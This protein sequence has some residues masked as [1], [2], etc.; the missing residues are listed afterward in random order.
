MARYPRLGHLSAAYSI[1]ICPLAVVKRS[2]ADMRR[3]SFSVVV[4]II[5]FS[6]GV[7]AAAVWMVR[8][9]P[10]LEPAVR[11]VDECPPLTTQYIDAFKLGKDGYFPQGVFFRDQ[12]TDHL[13]RNFFTKYLA[14]MQE[15][16]LLRFQPGSEESVY[17]FTWLRSFHSKVVIRVWTDGQMKTLFFKELKSENGGKNHQLAVEQTRNLTIDEWNEFVR[18]LNE[19]CVWRLPS[20]A[21]DAIATDGA[22][23]L[24]EV[25]SDRHYHVVA[26]QSP[27]DS[28]RD[29]CLY[30]L[31][32]TGLPLN[33]Q[34]EIY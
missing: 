28:Y 25:N 30:L 22:W 15:R 12:H 32:L 10:Q 13:A 5:T 26:R 34:R 14:E 2:F 33:S 3:L 27:Q 19:A 8:T 24:F 31:K 6:I 9:T 21:Q 16:S 7:I 20:G 11:I 1:A 17:R 23:W 29:L 4:A 18:L